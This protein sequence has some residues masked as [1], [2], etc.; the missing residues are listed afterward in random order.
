MSD[1]TDPDQK[2]NSG[3]PV[4]G[5]TARARRWP[6]WAALLETVKRVAFNV[7]ILA[8]IIVGVRSS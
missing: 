7:V 5:A 1:P 2:A 6:D 4:T 8:A 3:P